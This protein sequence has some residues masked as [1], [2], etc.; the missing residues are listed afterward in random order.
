MRHSHLDSGGY[1]YDQKHKDKD[2]GKAV[3][4]LVA[5]E[6]SRAFL[7]SMVACLFARGVYTEELLAE[8]LKVVGYGALADTI[9][10]VSRNIQKLRWQ[11][12]LATGFNPAS[13]SIPKRFTEVTT[14]KGKVDGE[15]LAGLKD[16]Y[17]KRILE[18]GAEAPAEVPGERRIL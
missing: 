7:T 9:D 16:A 18:L 14:W 4:F 5:D 8:C 1:A 17:A 6:A 3:D 13:I 12:R 2:V 15:F 11:T 10:A